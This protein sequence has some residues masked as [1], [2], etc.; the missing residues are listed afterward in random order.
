MLTA[1]HVLA[2]RQKGEL[3]LRKLTDDELARATTLAHALVR[4]AHA[5]TGSSRESLTAAFAALVDE[6]LDR[7]LQN[8]LQKLVLDTCEISQGD[9]SFAPDY[10]RELFVEAAQRRRDLKDGDTFDRAAVVSAVATRLGVSPETL[11]E[12]LFADLRDADRVVRGPAVNGDTLVASLEPEMARA[13]MLRAVSAVCT[14]RSRDAGAVRHFLRVLKFH[15]LLFE[16][17]AAGEG[18]FVVR[19]DG[20]FSLFESVTKYG[21]GFAMLLPALEALEAYEVEAEI[22]WGKERTRLVFRRSGGLGAGV[23]SPSATVVSDEA[24]K[25]LEGLAPLCEAEGLSVEPCAELLALPGVGVVV[26]DLVVKRRR[27]RVFVE[28]LGFWSRDAVWKR[29]EL[30]EAGLSERVVFCASERLRVR[31]SV[32]D[33][34]RA[35]LYV[36]KGVPQ[37]KKVLERVMRW[38]GREKASAKKPKKS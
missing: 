31:E 13:V 6:S 37:P 32:L 26:P 36:W 23:S 9:A 33:D 17:E 38:L 30:V 12:G 21:L 24:R 19:V 5:H 15:K 14:V 29:V 28:L 20:P 16:V 34:D 35:S 11:E 7:R 2:R 25:L 1:D 4:E 8:G 18:V 10:R 22:L 27:E 3:R